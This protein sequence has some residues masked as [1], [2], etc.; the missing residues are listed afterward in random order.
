MFFYM[1]KRL[2]FIRRFSRVVCIRTNRPKDYRSLPKKYTA[3]VPGPEWQ[4]IVMPIM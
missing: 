2:I 1:E 4:P 3:T